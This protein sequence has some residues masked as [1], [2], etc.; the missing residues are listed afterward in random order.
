METPPVRSVH[1]V[2]THAVRYLMMWHT[3]ARSTPGFHATTTS[4]LA[5]F[6][7]AR[8]S[9]LSL[10]APDRR[11]SRPHLCRRNTL[12]VQFEVRNARPRS[13][14]Q[15]SAPGVSNWVRRARLMVLVGHSFADVKVSNCAGASAPTKPKRLGTGSRSGKFSVVASC[16]SNAKRAPLMMPCFVARITSACW[17][18]LRFIFDAYRVASYKGPCAVGLFTLVSTRL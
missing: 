8:C 5:D 15:P 2:S 7:L 17:A 10:F 14:E 16:R 6:D 9:K 13:L 12:P 11:G 3:V 1:Y 18:F 4:D